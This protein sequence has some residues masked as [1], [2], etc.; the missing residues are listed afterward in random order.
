MLTAAF[1]STVIAGALTLMIALTAV[2]LW[3]AWTVTPSGSAGAGFAAA[4]GIGAWGDIVYGVLRLLLYALMAVWVALYLHTHFD[5]LAGR[6]FSTKSSQKPRTRAGTSARMAPPNG[7]SPTKEAE[8]EDDR[9]PL[10]TSPSPA[11]PEPQE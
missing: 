2:S 10:T 3:L 1:I 5:R 9:V 6:S 7:A 11:A 4:P 8:A